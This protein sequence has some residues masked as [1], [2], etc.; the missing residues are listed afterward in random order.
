M[1]EAPAVT[2]KGSSVPHTIPLEA[3]GMVP[4]YGP[5]RLGLSARL[6]NREVALA[7]IPYG[8]SS[9]ALVACHSQVDAWCRSSGSDRADTHRT[10]SL[11]MDCTH[12]ANYLFIDIM[13]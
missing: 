9:V 4:A 3:V 5:M 10:T 6:H 1:S 12:F 2:S 13:E 11:F 7:T 8:S